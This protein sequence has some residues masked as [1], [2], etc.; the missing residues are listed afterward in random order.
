MAFN[1]HFSLLSYLWPLIST[2]ASGR[3]SFSLF[4][5]FTILGRDK[6]KPHSKRETN[7]SSALFTD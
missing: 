5:I 7:L 1:F 4:T 6:Q 3:G 2:C